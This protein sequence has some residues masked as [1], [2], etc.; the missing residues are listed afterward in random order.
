[1]GGG[2]VDL[3]LSVT[4]QTHTPGNTVF[5]HSTRS[6]QRW[7]PLLTLVSDFAV[8]RGRE[9]SERLISSR[10][11]RAGVSSRNKHGSRW[12]LSP[13]TS[14]DITRRHP[15]RQGA[16]AQETQDSKAAYRLAW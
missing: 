11:C 3:C 12:R 15:D 2:H 4:G 9:P 1:M 14:F 8:F 16:H 7:K 13:S 6:L 10:A 5:A